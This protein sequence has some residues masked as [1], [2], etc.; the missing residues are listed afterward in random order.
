MTI[1]TAAPQ[2]ELARAEEE[3][4]EAEWAAQVA[5]QEAYLAQQAAAAEAAAA[6]LGGAPSDY[7]PSAYA[8]SGAGT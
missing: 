4:L 3:R 1:I 7:L 2:V 5:A 8:A 6:A